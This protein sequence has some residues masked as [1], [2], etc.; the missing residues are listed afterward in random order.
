MEK[1]G[2]KETRNKIKEDDIEKRMVEAKEMENPEGEENVL[3]NHRGLAQTQIF[4]EM[5]V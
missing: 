1:E 4:T 3:V 5:L 2:R